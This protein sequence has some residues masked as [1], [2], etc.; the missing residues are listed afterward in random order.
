MDDFSNQQQNNIDNNNQPL[1]S[2][3]NLISSNLNNVNKTN[4]EN[5]SLFI[6]NDN[7][8]MS[9]PKKIIMMIFY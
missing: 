8:N 3:V 4:I 1:V 7:N 5:S 2:L 9:I 6:N